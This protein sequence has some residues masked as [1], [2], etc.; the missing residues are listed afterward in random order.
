VTTDEYVTLGVAVGELAAL[1]AVRKATKSA[2]AEVKQ[3]ALMI[4]KFYKAREKA[5]VI[6][7]IKKL[8][9]SVKIDTKKLGNPIIRVVL[10]GERVTDEE[11]KILRWMPQLES[12]YLSNSR[13]TD[14][15]LANLNALERL[16]VL[17]LGNTKVTDKGLSNLRGLTNLTRLVLNKTAITNKG[18]AQLK[19]LKRLCHL[20]ISETLVSDT[21][22]NHLKSLS[23][24]NYLTWTGSKVTAHGYA[25]LQKV[26]PKLVER[27]IDF[28]LYHDLIIKA[29]EDFY[30]DDA[31]AVEAFFN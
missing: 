4:V 7:A 3:R 16:S 23:E 12:L 20:D 5:K 15:G 8:G 27:P 31:D 30:L 9:G 25:E 19:P 21:G 29:S 6:A 24:L 26:I 1:D 14:M 17:D 10:E 28:E 2:D 11:L 13:I 22:L 18:L